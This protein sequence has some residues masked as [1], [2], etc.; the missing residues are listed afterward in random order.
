MYSSIVGFLSFRSSA[1]GD[2]R[3]TSSGLCQPPGQVSDEKP[4]SGTRTGKSRYRRSRTRQSNMSA[5]LNLSV[6]GVGGLTI[7]GGALSSVSGER[8][9]R[10]ICFKNL[11][12][13]PRFWYP[14]GR[15][16]LV[17]E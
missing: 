5:K 16:G 14:P 7:T 11:S 12:S 9:K 2:F 15:V 8:S 17:S 4:A 6:H 13:S 3:K 1:E 10:S